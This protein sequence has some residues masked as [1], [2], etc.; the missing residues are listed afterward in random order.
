MRV[1]GSIGFLLLSLPLTVCPDDQRAIWVVA[2]D[3]AQIFYHKNGT[4]FAMESIARGTEIQFDRTE[5]ERCFLTYNGRP[6]YIRTKFLKTKQEF[7]VEEQKA[8]GLVLVD[9]IWMTSEQKFQSE[10]ILR[11]LVQWNEQWVTPEDKTNLKKGLVKYH[12]QWVTP[13]QRSEAEREEFIAAQ[14]AKGLVLHNDKWISMQVIKH[15][16]TARMLKQQGDELYKRQNIYDKASELYLQAMQSLEEYLRNEPSGSSEPE[17]IQFK[18][19]VLQRNLEVQKMVK[20]GLIV[21]LPNGHE[22]LVQTKPAQTER[23]VEENAPK[24]DVEKRKMAET[25]PAAQ[26]RSQ[27]VDASVPATIEEFKY[28]EGMEK[29]FIEGVKNGHQALELQALNVDISRLVDPW[30]GR[31]NFRAQFVQVY[32]PDWVRGYEQG[33]RHGFLKTTGY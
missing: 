8:K 4:P 27:V 11:G 18:S 32:G 23:A 21:R 25:K 7:F 15:L 29:G 16:E 6:A 10:Q 13:Q 17:V 28:N 19:D 14:R 12:S 33:F 9:G 1:L 5:G 20:D 2:E 30:N 26:K 31:M 22:G 3:G 24:V